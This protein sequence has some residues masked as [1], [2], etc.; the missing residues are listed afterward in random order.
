MY[1]RHWMQ[2]SLGISRRAQELGKGIAG[3]SSFPSSTTT[4]SCDVMQSWKKYP[5]VT[6]RSLQLLMAEVDYGIQVKVSARR[7]LG[8]GRAVYSAVALGEG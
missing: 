6:R 1:I 8:E 2:P 5:W 3:S 7:G 4:V